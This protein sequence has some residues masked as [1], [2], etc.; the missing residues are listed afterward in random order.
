MIP[1]RRHAGLVEALQPAR[2]L[3]DR[4][5]PGDVVYGAGALAA[6]ARRRGVVG[7]RR[8]RGA[9]R[10]APRCR[11]RRPSRRARCSS[12]ALAALGVGA[13]GA[14]A[15]EA[16][17]REL[18]RDLRVLGAPAARRRSVDDELVAAGPRSR[19]SAAASP[20][21]S[22][23]T[24]SAAEPLLPEVERVRAAD[25]PHDA[26]HHAGA[27]AAG[28]RARVL[29]EGQLGARAAELVGVEQVVDARV[30]LVDRLGDQPQAEHARVEVDVARRV[31][32]DR[33]DVVDALEV[34]RIWVWGLENRRFFAPL[35][36]RSRTLMMST[37]RP[38]SL[39]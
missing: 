3:V 13:V 28:R 19:R 36:A 4:R 31:A 12:S 1:R 23:S 25:A 33:G 5:A 20:S 39:V 9:R 38:P 14:H 11:R 10:A 32:G 8:R 16:L 2:V 15:V 22:V 24:P 34:Q 37:P 27:G 35:V 6:R 29:E 18:G 7:D 17:Q 21:R 30:V 26:V